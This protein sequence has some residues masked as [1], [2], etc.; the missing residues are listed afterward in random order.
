M[1]GRVENRNVRAVLQ[2]NS[3]FFRQGQNIEHTHEVLRMF[4]ECLESESRLTRKQRTLVSLNKLAV[5]LRKG[6]YS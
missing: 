4:E 2:N 6:K 1:L 3:L 5:L